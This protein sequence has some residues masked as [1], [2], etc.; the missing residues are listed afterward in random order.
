[1]A[2]IEILE[3]DVEG[4]GQPRNDGSRGSALYRVPFKLSATPSNL[5]AEIAVA[6]WDRPPSYTTMH[7]PGIASVIGDRFILDGTDLEEVEAYHAK[8]LKLVIERANELCR[9]AEERT[10]AEERRKEAEEKAH[11]ENVEAVAKRIKFD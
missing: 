11:A 8:T 6:T 2:D 9:E 7:R 1:M 4:V 3:V 5:W 10:R